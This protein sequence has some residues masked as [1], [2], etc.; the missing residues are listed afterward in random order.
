METSAVNKSEEEE[1]TCWNLT[2]CRALLKQLKIQ[3]L[4]SSTNHKRNIREKLE[5]KKEQEKKEREEHERDIQ[6]EME[7]RKWTKEKEFELELERERIRLEKLKVEVGVKLKSSYIEANT[8]GTVVRNYGNTVKLPKLE[9]KKFDGNTLKWQEVWDAFD[10]TIHQNE[11]LQRVDKFNYLRRQLVGSANETIVG[12][13]L[14][15]DN[16]DIAIKLLKERYG[17]KHILIDT[18]YAQLINLPIA[19]NKTLSLKLYFDLTEKHLRV[20]SALGENIEQKQFLSMMKSKLPRDVISKLE[21]QK[22][23]NYEWTAETFRKRLKRYITA[24]EP[25]DQQL[26]LYQRNENIFRANANKP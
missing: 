24:Q 3:K 25:G 12:L 8:E 11:R 13:D 10:S 20:F 17:K 19:M 4:T 6:R 26:R 23:E 21:E 16:Y 5:E 1:K 2:N 18:H 7:E 14:T 22:H 9:L 15:N